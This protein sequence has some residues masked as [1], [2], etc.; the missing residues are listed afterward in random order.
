VTPEQQLMAKIKSECGD[1]IRE[2]IAG[3]PYPEAF[4]AALT[5]N[6]SGGDTAAA[7][8]ELRVFYELAFVILG[9]KANLGSTRAQDL[10]AWCDA[11][12][13]VAVVDGRPVM[14]QRKFAESLLSLVNLATS[15]GPTQIMG[16]QALAGHYSLSELPNL[17]THFKR[18]VV[19]LEDFARRFKLWET[20]SGAPIGGSGTWSY[21]DSASV[22]KLFRCWNTGRPDG[23]TADPRYVDNGLDR[24]GIYSTL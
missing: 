4:L 13:Q 9:R 20:A 1:W 21:A 10:L 11:P 16:Y 6:E 23:V 24:M 3:T 7:R 14:G 5:A 8:F 2:A 17:Q 15:W 12:M 19:M 22:G 18:T